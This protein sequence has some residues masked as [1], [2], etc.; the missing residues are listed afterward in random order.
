MTV[1]GRPEPLTVPALVVPRN[2]GSDVLTVQDRE[3]AAPGPGQVRVT[4]AAAGINF[5]DIYQREG[6]YP[7]P[8][9][10]VVG[11]EGA[12][13]VEA[14]GDGVDLAV[15]DRV[16]WANGPGSAAGAVVVDAAR[17]VRVPDGVDLEVAGAVMLQGITAHYLVNSTYAVQPGDLVLAHAVAGGV[18][19]LLVQLVKAKGATLI[20][21]AGSAEK[22]A[23][24]L[25]LGADHVIDYSELS[26]LGELPGKVK[27]LTGGQGVH[28]V[29]DGV[30]E[31]TFDASL[32]TLRRRG[33]MV[34]YGGASGQVPPFDIQRLNRGGSLFLT[35]PTMGDYIATRE[36]LEWRTSE[37]LGA[38]ADGSLKVDVGGRYPITEARAAYDALAGRQTTG[39]LLLI[40]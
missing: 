28:V 6:V 26:D 33:M 32:A 3:I 31:S 35:R 7:V 19:Q 1:S 40:P 36:E 20:G 4:V 10:F 34:L 15:G 23:L 18:G 38:V 14:L 17:V 2:G 12:G 9:P 8:T 11:G 25:G 27:E 37:I 30:G 22:A 21:T 5:I 13:T 39:K 24:G 29:Y 16:A